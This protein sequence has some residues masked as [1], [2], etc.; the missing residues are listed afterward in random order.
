MA[1]AES[2]HFPDS[3]GTGIIGIGNR[4]AP[5]TPMSTSA[6][7]ISVIALLIVVVA[8]DTADDG[9]SKSD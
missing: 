2:K 6:I 8:L 3:V 5:V 7:A 4:K 1:D 9:G